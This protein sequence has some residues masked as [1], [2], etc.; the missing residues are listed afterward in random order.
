MLNCITLESRAKV[1]SSLVFPTPEKTI[2]FTSIPAFIAFI[3][4]PPETTSAP[5]PI[6]F[7]SLSKV[8]LELDLTEKHIKGLLAPGMLFEEMGINYYGPIDG[9][10]TINLVK[11][12]KNMQLKG[13]CGIQSI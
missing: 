11:T 9:H 10:D 4:S 6:F 8:I 13:M 7:N 1:S 5:D 2:F 3:N 12:L